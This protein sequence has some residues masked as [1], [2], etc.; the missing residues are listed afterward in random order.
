MFRSRLI[1][2]LLFVII[3]LKS[4]YIFIFKSKLEKS[5]LLSKE[6]IDLFKL[7]LES[8]SGSW[9]SASELEPR[10]GDNQQEPE[11]I[12]PFSALHSSVKKC[13]DIEMDGI[14]KKRVSF[15]NSPK[16]TSMNTE[17]EDFSIKVN[18]ENNIEIFRS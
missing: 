9:E 16:S 1:I 15:I 4:H 11:P 6:S 17:V 2:I 7:D 8:S 10:S 5:M 18:F 13:L 12:I 3:I 14:M